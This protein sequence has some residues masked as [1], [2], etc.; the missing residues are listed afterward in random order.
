M[1]Q[2]VESNRSNSRATSCCLVWTG[3]KATVGNLR[4]CT[5]SI[6]SLITDVSGFLFA[7]RP[8]VYELRTRR[9]WKQ[10]LNASNGR[11]AVISSAEVI[12]CQRRFRAHPFIGAARRRLRCVWLARYMTSYLCSTVSLSLGEIV[13]ELQAVKVS[14]TI[15]TTTTRWRT[16]R[17]ISIGTFSLCEAAK[18]RHCACAE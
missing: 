7:Y 13:V 12:K 10:D 1:R 8:T 5:C 15:I 3:L 16:S 17:G 4:A 18:T 11:V 9:W 14:R 2:L 6:A